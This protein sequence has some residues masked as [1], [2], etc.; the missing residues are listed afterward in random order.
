MIRFEL[1]FAFFIFAAQFVT[2]QSILSTKLYRNNGK[3]VIDIDSADF[4]R[5]V[6]SPDS[7]SSLFIIKEFFPDGRKK[8]I[9]HSVTM[10]PSYE[11]SYIS[12]H[13]NGSKKEVSSY[14][15]G[16]L[17]DTV[18][19]FYPNGQLYTVKYEIPWSDQ[20]G[21]GY[22]PNYYIQTMRDT[23]G[24]TT[25]RDGKGYGILYN[26]DFSSITASGE[27]KDGIRDGIWTGELSLPHLVF[28]EIYSK[29]KLISG[30]STESD[31][32]INQYTQDFLDPSPK[33][34][35]E[36]FNE[37]LRKNLKYPVAA[38][39]RQAQ[40]TF[41]VEFIVR[42][43]GSFEDIHVAGT[44]DKSL[45]EE[46]ISVVKKSAPWEPGRIKGKIVE[47]SYHQVVFFKLSN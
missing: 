6:Q 32:T 47:V 44:I 35:R 28:T 17:S 42:K 39:I 33:G 29:G 12:F 23:T 20:P 37:Y 21:A 16:T 8:S 38:Q 18:Y 41:P 22:G 13:E 45:A 46:A 27:F 31:G 10:V 1:F 43:D 3:E 9:A 2:A 7:G 40:G 24:K 26:D 5:I 14:H 19:N 25:V 36:V 15:N 30:E 34:G 11:G 4:L